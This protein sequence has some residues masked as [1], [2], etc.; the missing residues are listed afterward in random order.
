[1]H[2]ARTIS[3]DFVSVEAQWKIRIFWL[4]I[5]RIAMSKAQNGNKESKKPKAD[6]T[7]STNHVSAY[8][9]AQGLGAATADK[10][11][12]QTVG[13]TSEGGGEVPQCLYLS[14]A[15]NPWTRSTVGRA[16]CGWYPGDGGISRFGGAY[17]QS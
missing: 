9:A 4:S 7:Q 3:L 8:K 2:I 13:A 6:K 17:A 14:H 5:R 1:L 15:M 11:G 16:S 10:N 12:G